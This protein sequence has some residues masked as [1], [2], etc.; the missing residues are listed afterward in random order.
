MNRS[1]LEHI[2]R[3]AGDIAED[4]EIVVLGSMAVLAQ[5]P[6]VS[7]DLLYSIEADIYP[8]NKPERA[9]VIDGCIGELSP[10]HQTFG[11]YAHGIGPETAQNLPN[12]WEQ[13]LV[14]LKNPNT[15]GITGWCLE[16][17]D[18]VVGKYVSGR[19]KDLSFARK[20]IS[21]G[22]VSQETLKERVEWLELS[23]GTKNQ[24]IKK[25]N[26]EMTKRKDLI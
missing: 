21:Q 5:F 6:D 16:I 22:L 10:F 19:E 24:I 11:Y 2:I 15:R 9:E 26:T 8:K 25:I 18:L 3:A 17:H 14:P 1:Q 4:D 20:A 7:P 23:E 13:R 12:G